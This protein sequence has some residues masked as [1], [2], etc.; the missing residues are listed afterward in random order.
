MGGGSEDLGNIGISDYMLVTSGL[1]GFPPAIVV[2]A[3]GAPP[4]YCTLQALI[5]GRPHFVLIACGVPRLLYLVIVE[6]WL[7]PF[8]LSHQIECG[9]RNLARVAPL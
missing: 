4:P 3:L 1:G 8:N 7:T 2:I 6:M 9:R 5:C